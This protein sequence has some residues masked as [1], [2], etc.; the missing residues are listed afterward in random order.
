M[1]PEIQFISALGPPGSGKGTQCAR[2]KERY[3]CEHVS[4]GDLLRA[5]ADDPDSSF[6]KILREDWN[7]RND[8]FPWK[9]E[10]AGYFEEI[11]GSIHLVL[12]L[13]SPVEVLED[14]LLQR[15]RTD[16]METIR[17]QIV[18]FEETTAKVLETYREKEMVMEVNAEGEV[19]VVFL[20]IQEAF[21]KRAVKVN[22]R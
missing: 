16:D 6:S 2:L 14:R 11:V 21:E 7:E 19:D 4:V 10:I 1:I 18:V 3:E 9:V 8:G 22:R 13:S 20:H 12:L 5:E 15:H 17:K